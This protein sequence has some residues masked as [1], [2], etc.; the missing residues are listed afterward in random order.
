MGGELALSL[1]H[2][3]QIRA[4]F[5]AYRRLRLCLFVLSRLM[6]TSSCN[7]DFWLQH[8]FSTL[9]TLQVWRH[10]RGKRS[11]SA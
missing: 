6:S 1:A 11:W 7:T 4:C 10:A 3:E 2:F 8:V 9:W 5:S